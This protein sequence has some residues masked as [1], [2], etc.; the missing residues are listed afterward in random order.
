MIVLDQIVDSGGEVEQQP[1]D[2]NGSEARAQL[3]CSEPLDQEKEDDDGARN[4]NDG[5]RREV[6]S[7]N[8]YSLDGAQDRLSRHEDTVSYNQGHADNG[9]DLERD[10]SNVGPLEEVPGCPP[11]AGHLPGVVSLQAKQG[12]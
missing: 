5:A 4:S 10:F 8:P 7:Y 3:G 12:R 6:R 9:N 1:N 2:D 11:H